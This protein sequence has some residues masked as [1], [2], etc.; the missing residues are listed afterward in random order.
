[1]SSCQSRQRAAR[2]LR[3]TTPRLSVRAVRANPS[4]QRLGPLA[5]AF[6][7]VSR[8]E[9]RPP[10][11]A[12]MGLVL[13]V[14]TFGGLGWWAAGQPG[15][16]LKDGDYGCSPAVVG[17]ISAGPGA[18]VR[19]GELVKVWDFNMSTGKKV[20]LE[21]S[22]FDRTDPSEFSVVSQMAMRSSGQ[23]YICTLD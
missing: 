5:S 7:T 9:P 2:R 10:N 23:T 15:I 3:A 11:L 20:R 21:W 19:G 22:D 16:A 12:G 13:S 6:V 18:T 4:A 14:A 1:M 17:P 8:T